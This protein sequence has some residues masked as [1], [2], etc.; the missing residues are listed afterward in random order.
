MTTSYYD[1]SLS[2]FPREGG[3]FLDFGE[4]PWFEVELGTRT[5]GPGPG[6]V[7]VIV[8]G[9]EGHVWLRGGELVLEYVHCAINGL[10]KRRGIGYA[11]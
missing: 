11:V 2:T 8:G 1:K 7:D 5:E 9:A 6:V 4:S 3:D 10:W